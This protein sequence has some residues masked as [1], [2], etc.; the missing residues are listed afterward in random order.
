MPLHVEVV[1]PESILYEGEAEQV[2]CRPTGGEIAFLP[3]HQPFVGALE[4]YPVRVLLPGSGEVVIAV[5]GGFVEVRDDRVTVLSDVAELP[6]QID[7][8]RAADRE[9]D[10]ARPRWPPTRTTS[11]PRQRWRGPSCGCRSPGADH[12]RRPQLTARHSRVASARACRD[13][14]ACTRASWLGSSRVV[15]GAARGRSSVRSPAC[16][17]PARPRVGD[18]AGG[19]ERPRVPRARHLG[20]R[21]RLRTEVPGRRRRAAR[22]HAGVGRRHGPPRRED[23]STS[24]RPRTTPA[25]RAT[26]VD[27]RLVGD[28]L[29]RAHRRGVQVVAWYLPHFA[30]VDR[31]LRYIQRDVRV[32]EPGRALRRHRARRRVDERREGPGRSATAR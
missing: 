26:L 4:T 29:R 7:V 16:R 22:G 17:R 21:L 31:D 18:G 30:D 20:R 15:V 8:V 12:R 3:G 5:H 10:G 32:P 28:I 11:R 6:E 2:V 1:S 23:A 19:R 25:P 14:D 24:R 27:R 13:A 9:G